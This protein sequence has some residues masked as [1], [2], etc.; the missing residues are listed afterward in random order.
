MLNKQ[1]V[2]NL[3]AEPYVRSGAP[4]GVGE[5]G[6]QGSEVTSSMVC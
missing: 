4:G 3:E 5:T 1:Q 6:L 2:I